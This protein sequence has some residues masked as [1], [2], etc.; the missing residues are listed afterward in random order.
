MAEKAIKKKAESA[1]ER[2]ESFILKHRRVI[3]GCVAGAVVIAA[4]VCAAV[5]ITESR[6]RSALAAI[7]AAE[8][9]YTNNSA[10]L[11]EAEAVA[12]S[13]AVEQAVS[14]YL[15]RRGVAGVRA[16]M[17]SAEAAYQRG[18]YETAL[19]RYLAAA[20]ADRR[21]YTYA[22]NMY[23]A[24]VCAEELGRRDDAVSYYEAAADA[25][26]FFLASHALFNLGRLSES[27]GDN[28]KA[29]EYYQRAIDGHSGDSWANLSQSR[30]I[31]LRAKGLVD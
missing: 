12:R 26:D 7:D 19:A 23:N 10:D 14:P 29:A 2:I 13:D 9:A 16:N 11:D 4:A 24:A 25:E 5:V 17:L 31:D 15:A 30:L 20:D 1:D 22:E 3:L 18:D 21:A 27:A 28:A 6:K 8:Y